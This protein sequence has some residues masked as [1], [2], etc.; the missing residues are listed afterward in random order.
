M[1]ITRFSPLKAARVMQVVVFCLMLL[2]FSINLVF[3][4][5]GIKPYRVVS[6][7]MAPEY[8]VGDIL[9]SVKP[10]GKLAEGDVA[11]YRGTWG[12]ERVVH[13]VVEVSEGGYMFKG[14]ANPTR[15]PQLVKDEEVEGVV[16]GHPSPLLSVLLSPFMLIGLIVAWFVA[17]VAEWWLLRKKKKEFGYK[18]QV[19]GRRWKNQVLK[20]SLNS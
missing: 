4:T 12:P 11:V 1:S 10:K 2:V 20:Y 5:A 19:G 13:R 18:D 9:L 17:G 14:D 6:K 16:F 3:S 7:S 8:K 15:D